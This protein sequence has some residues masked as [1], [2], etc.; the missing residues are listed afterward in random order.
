M[1]G[2]ASALAVFAVGG[3]VA[4]AWVDSPAELAADTAAPNP[5]VLT[6]VVQYKALT[7]TVVLSGT[8]APSAPVSAA[9]VSVAATA[10][11]PGGGPLVVTGVFTAPGK[12]VT[13]GQPLVEYSGRPVYALPGAVPA[14][15]DMLPGESGKD[16]VQLQ[17]ALQ[18]AGFSCGRDT[19]GAFGDGT[20]DAVSRFYANMGYAAP[21]TGPATQQAVAAAQR[22]YDQQSAVVGQLRSP[23]PRAADPRAAAVQLAQAE[24]TLRADATALAQAQAADGPMVPMSEVL[25]VPRLPAVVLSVPAVVGAAVSKQLITVAAGGLQL[26]G[27]LDPV[28][29]VFVRTGMKVQVSSQ[30]TA[31]Q[32]AGTVSA[33]G[34]VTP[35]QGSNGDQGAGGGSY[36]P[37]SIAPDQPWDESLE[38]QTVRV[39]ISEAATDS[40]VLAVPEAALSSGADGRTTVT[41]LDASGAQSVVQV[42]AGTSADGLVAVTATD[43]KLT[44]GQRVVVGR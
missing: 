6:A 41:V 42:R 28:Y 23:T 25:F 5:D 39:T 3:L 18:S 29:A 13:S 35:S 4:S 8:I 27:R 1:L 19:S 24:Q 44:R 20:K 31:L 10:G 21:T 36:V 22:A 15:R 17:R 9:P 26:T 40:P 2:G 34:M 43:A 37:V 16:I 11:N 12:T 30:A 38:G 33:V 7:S 14:Y 32:A